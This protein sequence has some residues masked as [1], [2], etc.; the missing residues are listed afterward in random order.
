VTVLLE[1]AIE[2]GDSTGMRAVLQSGDVQWMTAGAGIVH[3]EN[4]ADVLRERG[5]R[6]L[7]L[8][9][10][11]NLPRALKSTPP[12]YQDTAAARIPVDAEAG[13][14]ARVIAGEA[15]GVSAVI[16]THTPMTLVDYT[17]GPG[18]EVVLAYP[19]GWTAFLHVVV[20]LIEVGD[21]RVGEA[22][23]ALLGRDGSGIQFRNVGSRQARVVLGGGQPIDEPLV[24]Y[25][26]FA[27][28]THAEI[29]QAFDDYRA[30]RMGR[31]ANP[32]YDRVR[33]R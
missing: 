33:A 4:P 16:G 29:R 5:G 15:N 31:V 25:G 14:T 32:T 6:V 18:S 19:P 11:V 9:L 10:W 12:K 20:G 24:R 30:G 28:N 8:Q 17:L 13:V 2:H 26:P 7:G 21:T 22:H 23:L 27:M 1:G 3:E